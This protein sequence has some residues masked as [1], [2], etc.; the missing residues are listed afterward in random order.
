MSTLIPIDNINKYLACFFK[1][2]YIIHTQIPSGGRVILI[3]TE[4][5]M[6]VIAVQ[7]VGPVGLKWS[8]RPLILELQLPLHCP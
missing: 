2:N 5:I 3:P 4:L 6:P 8:F 1:L 7:P